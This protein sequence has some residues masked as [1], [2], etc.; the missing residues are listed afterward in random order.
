MDIAKYIGLFLL[1]NNFVYVPG[2]GNLELKKKSAAF[3]G[4]ALQAPTFEVLLTASGSIDDN[5]ANFIATNEQT[6]ISK[7][8]NS[9]RDFSQQA[10]IDLQNG[11]KVAIPAIGYF[12]EERSKI[13]F[14]VD[15][16]FQYTPPPLPTIRMAKKQEEPVYNSSI[17]MPVVKPR[18]I[19][20]EEEPE[21]TGGISWAKVALW[22]L[23]L[24]LLIFIGYFGYRYLRGSHN[25][26]NVPITPVMQDTTSINNHTPLV[27]TTHIDTTAT[28]N[29][30]NQAIN[31]DVILNSYTILSKAEQRAAKLKTFGHN[32]ELVSES[33]SSMFYV[34]LP[35]SKVNPADTSALLDSLTRVFN[36]S[37]G[38]R[39]LQ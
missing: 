5:L 16:N 28:T 34:V 22:V 13:R 9:L 29:V 35:V 38:V 19:D 32:V 14:V 27:D 26:I 20:P 4:E 36:P 21:T 25:P 11:K 39:I 30:N 12:E 6:S 2:L 18:Y 8:S 33:D 15:S 37:H 1:K 10:R 17:D 3:T 24:L 23:A 7:A 31:I